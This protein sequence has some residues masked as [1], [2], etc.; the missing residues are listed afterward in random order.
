MTLTQS[1]RTALSLS[2][3]ELFDPRASGLSLGQG[4]KEQRFLCPLCGGG[5]SK[6]AAHRCLSLNP[7]NGVWHC[8]R[9]R[10]GGKLRE[11][12]GECPAFATA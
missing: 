12:W 4:G 8:H 11:M 6:D 9:C 3:L 2:D 5:K 1:G 10:Q 7:Q